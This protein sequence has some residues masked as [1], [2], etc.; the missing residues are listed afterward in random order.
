MP[1]AGGAL[2]R[3][4]LVENDPIYR[5]CFAIHRGGHRQKALDWFC[6][7]IGVGPEPSATPRATPR[8]PSSP[9][10]AIM[11]FVI[12][13]HESIGDV[14]TADA[15]VLLLTEA[16][17][18]A[19]HVMNTIGLEITDDS[20]EALTYYHGYLVREIHKSLWHERKQNDS[21]SREDVP[22]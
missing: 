11:C 20:E 3:I 7:R 18:A 22:G 1:A 16:L 17:H 2:K 19:L 8:L 5:T 4:H 21:S 6:K 13:F 15:A 12:W 9:S 10:P 14:P